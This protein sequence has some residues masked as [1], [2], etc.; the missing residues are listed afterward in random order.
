MLRR[1][2]HRRACQAL[3]P[4]DLGGQQAALLHLLLNHGPACQ[5]EVA[6]TLVHDPAATAKA[7]DTL[8]KLGYVERKDDPKDRRRWLITLS[9]VGK[10]MAL[11]VVDVLNALTAEVDAAL[12]SDTAAFNA[13]IDKLTQALHNPNDARIS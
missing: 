4:L 8:I 5:A 2:L 10:K 11:R 9:P 7:I 1:L 3:A 12:G 13:S 6:R